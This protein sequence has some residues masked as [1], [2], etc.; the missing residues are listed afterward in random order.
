MAMESERQRTVTVSPMAIGELTAV[1]GLSGS[2]G[3]GN[4]ASAPIRAA[5]GRSPAASARSMVRPANRSA[6]IFSTAFSY[7]RRSTMQ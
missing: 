5:G 6:V 7:N 4:R 2:D 3:G 1:R